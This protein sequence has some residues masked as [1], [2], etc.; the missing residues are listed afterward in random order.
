MQ[1]PSHA[2]ASIV[3]SNYL[4]HALSLYSYIQE[5]NPETHFL[6]LI[7][8]E[9][10][11]LP[12]RLPVG[13]EWMSWD[14]LLDQE[15]RFELSEEYS[16]FELSCILRGRLHHYLASQRQFDKWIML[17]TDVGILASLNPIWAALDGHCIAL[18]PHTTKPVDIQQ[19]VPHESSFLK[20]GLFNAGVVGMKRSETAIKAADWLTK[21]LER[22]GHSYPARLHAGQPRG[23][24]FE[25]VDQIWVNLMYIYFNEETAIIN[26]AGCNLGHWN[27]C[28]G[29]IVMHDDLAYFND[30]P[31]VIA[32][33]SGLP[34]Q[35]KLA[36]VT[37]YS[38]LYVNQPSQA[39]AALARDYLERLAN[40]QALIPEIPYSYQQRSKEEVATYVPTSSLVLTRVVAPANTSIPRTIGKRL[41]ALASPNKLV[42]GL[43]L[44][45]W[46]LQQIYRSM[47]LLLHHADAHVFRDR[48]ENS[49][50]GLTPCIGNYETY[51]TRAWIL[52]AVQKAHPSFHGKLL[53]VGAGSSPYENLIMSTGRVEQYIKLD[54]ADS[55]Y[56]RGHQ[57]D[58]TWDGTTIPL[59]A[60]SIDTIIM[61]EVLEHVRQPAA[62]LKEVRRVLKTGGVLFLTVPFSWPMH[63]LPYDYH[64]FTPIAM[65]TYL[66]DAGFTVQSLD[67]LGGCDHALA[68]QIGLWLTNRTMGENKRKLAKLLAWPVY[69]FLLNKGQGEYTAIRNHQMHIGLATLSEAS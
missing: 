35:D 60:Q 6:V 36:Q 54:F 25:F 52:R 24:D 53:D 15:T 27:L 11:D 31:I 62:L 61:T 41:R 68:Q 56:H 66:K 10:S 29:D 3:T 30:E 58:L 42:G 44:L 8:G 55:E 32:H 63:E 28:Q 17:D 43:K 2:I 37:T 12:P 40:A 57:L 49:F 1:T 16:P 38:Q 47:P 69:A 34:E 64:R 13:P 67:I 45:S 39:W 50:T 46:K 21:R 9:S 20:S 59:A 23:H 48:S 51:L 33:F 22:F 65:N 26:Q 5:T 19:S 18:T 7:I 14:A 4:H